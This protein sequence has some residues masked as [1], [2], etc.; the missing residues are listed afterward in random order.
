MNKILLGTLLFAP[1]LATAATP[2]FDCAKAKGAAETLIC[3]DA[4]LAALDNELAALYPKAIAAFS[5]EQQ[6]SERAM[7]RGWIKGRNECWK[8][9]DLRQCVEESYQ[10]R[11]TELQIKGG[12]LRVPSPVDYQCANNVTLSTYFYNEARRPAAMINLSEGNNQQ[13]VLAYQTP[14][15]SGTR[16]E[17]QNLTLFT[18]GSDARLERYGEPTLSCTEIPT[19]GN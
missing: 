6:K 7:Q 5:P 14:S 3:Q 16:Y 4:G 9:G 10:L 18:K 19:K 11:I 13:Q 1:L 15:A 2:S 17:G 12:Q 8:A